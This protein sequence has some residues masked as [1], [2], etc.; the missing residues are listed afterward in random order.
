MLLPLLPPAASAAQRCP[1]AAAAAAAQHSC[2]G[3]LML[4]RL[5]QQLLGQLP[6]GLYLRHLLLALLLMRGGTLQ[7]LLEGLPT[8]LPL[9]LGFLQAQTCCQ[10]SLVLLLLSQGAAV[11]AGPAVVA[12]AAAA[13]SPAVACQHQGRTQCQSPRDPGA[14]PPLSARSHEP[15]EPLDLHGYH[16]C[17]VTAPGILLICQVC[18]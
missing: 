4:G 14:E 9:L 1:A 12:A 7:L 18:H 17:D 6:L 2:Q 3:P 11:V 5:N 8:C 13:A 10:Q 16:V 15:P